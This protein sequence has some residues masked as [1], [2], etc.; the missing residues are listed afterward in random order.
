MRLT[1]IVRGPEG[2]VSHSPTGREDHEVSNG[3]SRAVGLTGQHGEDA[4]VSVVK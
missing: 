1:V 2:L 4:G 3:H